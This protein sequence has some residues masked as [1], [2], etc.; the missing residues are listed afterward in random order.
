MASVHDI[1]ACP[2]CTGDAHYE[3]YTR[4]LEESLFCPRCGYIE[5]TRPVMDR[6]KQKQDP[7]R[8]ARFKYRRDGEP[9]FRTTPCAGRGAHC[10]AQKNGVSTVGA[11]GRR[12]PTRHQIESFQRDLARPEI[13]ATRSYLTRWNARRRRVEVVVGQLPNAVG[14]LNE[15]ND[16]D[17][18]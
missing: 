16:G 8:R 14:L 10:L 18:E 4:T 12:Y 1:V 11:N 15:V 5:H 17:C 7:Q 13:D 6:R 3:F 9:I 2:Q